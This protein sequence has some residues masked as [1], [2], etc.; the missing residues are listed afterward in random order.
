FMTSGELN[1]L[2]DIEIL[3]D[4]PQANDIHEVVASFTLLDAE[5]TSTAAQS[6]FLVKPGEKI[7]GLF[8]EWVFA[9]NPVATLSV[10]VSNDWRFNVNQQQV[11]VVGGVPNETQSV[12]VLVPN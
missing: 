4:T 7:F 8:D 9:E 11:A 5:G 1:S 6:T 2:A 12:T 3:S 10:T